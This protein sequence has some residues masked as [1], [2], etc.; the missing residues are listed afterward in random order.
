M[1][2]QGVVGTIM[3][4]DMIEEQINECGSSICLYGTL[5]FAT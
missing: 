3:G 4:M 1:R 2:V 5:L